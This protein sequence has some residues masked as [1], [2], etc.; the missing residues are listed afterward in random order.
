M[1]K[2]R[3]LI[4]EDDELITEVLN[5][6]LSYDYEVIKTNNGE[7]ALNIIQSSPENYFNL[8]LLDIMMP[9]LNGFQ[10]LERIRHISLPVLILSAKTNP[11]DQVNGL[12]LGAWGYS[13]KPFNNNILL[14]QIKNLVHIGILMKR[15][16]SQKED[17]KT[18]REMIQYR[19]AHLK[20]V[21]EDANNEMIILKENRQY[22][23]NKQSRYPD[24]IQSLK[25]I[26]YLLND[27]LLEL[28]KYIISTTHENHGDINS[29]FT[30]IHNLTEKLSQLIHENY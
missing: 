25:K 19:F 8:L 14:S 7:T 24:L 29:Q 20:A 5:D 28:Y 27:Q 2:S 4:A 18:K 12:N 9:K 16:E 22:Q 13:T 11:T 3:I 10:V 23:Y 21:L 30:K 6:L 26:I 1:N 17:E 15:I